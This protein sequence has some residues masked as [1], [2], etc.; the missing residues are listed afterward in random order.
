MTRP[1]AMALFPLLFLLL[2]ALQGPPP[3]NT[4]TAREKAAGWKL[5]FD[6]RSTAGWRGY[7][8]PDMPAGWQVRHGALTRVTSAGDIVTRRQYAD[9]DLQFD[10]KIAK[11]GN[12]GVM[13]HVTEAAAEPYETG[14]EYQVLDDANF[15]PD[16]ES[17][18][19]SAGSCY[20]LYAIPSHLAT[21]AG[22]WNHSRLL[23]QHGHVTHW[24]NGTL[25]VRYVVGSADWDKR[26]AGSK[27]KTWA[28]FGKATTGFIDLQDHGSVVAYRNI[29]I[30]ELR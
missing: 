23:V 20:G 28:G 12:S 11:G 18:L 16:G 7:R 24:L 26:V 5:L 9:F 3:P 21:P 6:G 29:K 10:W 25:A 2:A 19:T 4:L 13:Y 30:R 14:P 8:K 17:L 27:F 15:K 1:A 22:E